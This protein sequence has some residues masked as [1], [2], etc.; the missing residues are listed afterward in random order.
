[1]T[2]GEVA[3]LIAAIAFVFLVGMAA[4]P[5]FKLGKVL[6]ELATAVK[7]VGTGTT[8]ILNELKET[9]TVTNQE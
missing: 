1:M 5:L 4:I 3:G 8:P 7:D 2:V 9:V 6:D